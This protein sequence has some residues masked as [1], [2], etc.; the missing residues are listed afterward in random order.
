M[1]S[2]PKCWSIWKFTFS[3]QFDPRGRRR[4]TV[5]DLPGPSKIWKTGEVT[6]TSF[7][8]GLVGSAPGRPTFGYFVTLENHL[9][10]P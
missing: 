6:H 5:H 8:N 9:Y 3:T 1:S 4:L 2:F 7:V 10:R